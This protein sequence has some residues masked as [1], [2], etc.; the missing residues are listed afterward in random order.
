MET[1]LMLDWYFLSMGHLSHD[2]HVFQSH[3]SVLQWLVLRSWGYVLLFSCPLN[4]VYQC[5]GGISIRT[6]RH[7]ICSRGGFSWKLL[8]QTLKRSRSAGLSMLLRCRQFTSQPKNSNWLGCHQRRAQNHQD[9]Q[10]QEPSDCNDVSTMGNMRWFIYHVEY[11]QQDHPTCKKH[12]AHSGCQT[13]VLWLSMTL[14]NR[15]HEH[16]TPLT[17]HN[18]RQDANT[19]AVY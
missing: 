9:L 13:P 7:F 6:W 2:D 16:I 5:D 19:K 15:I 10:K 12:L 17:T 11:S 1:P 3:F 8:W 14:T 4:W 18:P